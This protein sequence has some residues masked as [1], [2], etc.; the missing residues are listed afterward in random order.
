MFCCE[1]GKAASG[2]FCRHCGSP[3]AQDELPAVV[4]AAAPQTIEGDWE[5]E[6]RY[7]HILKFPGVRDTIERHA[8]LAPKRM[9]G[10]QFLALADKLVPLG[11]SLEG[12]AGAVQPIYER[13]GVKTGKE[14]QHAVQAPVGRVIVRALCSLARHGQPLHSVA[15]S[16][17]GCLLEAALPSDLFSLSG[18]LLVGVR[19]GPAATEVHAATRIGGQFFDWGKSARCLDQL[20]HDL[21]RDAA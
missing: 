10:E 19:R 21:Q 3:L 18:Q 8:R 7:E 9:S 12:L 6:V 17:D 5:N 14:V 16:A 4:S 1:C 13:L 11:V 20:F 2:K 15:Q